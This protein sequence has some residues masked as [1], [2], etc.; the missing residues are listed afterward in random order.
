MAVIAIGV[1]AFLLIRF[2]QQTSQLAA[3][4][5]AFDQHAREASDALTEA[6]VA[7]HGYVAA[8]QGEDFWMSKVSASTEAFT[9]ALSVLQQSATAA[10]RTSI[11][12]A[13]ASATEFS[14]VDKRVRE[15]LK[16]DQQLMAAD[17]IFTEGSDAAATAGRQIETARLAGRQA[18]DRQAANIRRQEATTIGA[19]AAITGLIV[20]LL[21]PVR[22]SA[23]EPGAMVE[24]SS[25]MSI[26]PAMV[27]APAPAPV[28]KPVPP[29]APVPAPVPA[30]SRST[31]T[32]LFRKTADLATDFGRV[33]D[34]DEL[35]R[36]LA[37]AADLVDASGLM[38]WMAD[39]PGTIRPVMAHGYSTQM[40]A[41]MP[42]IARSADNAAAKA[43]RSGTLQIVLSRP[44]GISGAVVAPIMSP[45]G[46]IGALSAEIR[47]GAE[48][49][50]SVQ[51]LA[52]IFAAHLASVLATTSTG[53]EIAETRVATS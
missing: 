7:Q 20:M 4:L 45:D 39:T 19:A 35:T 33:R 51:A 1:S 24:A 17:V 15:Y 53:S 2:E 9:A 48:T 40:I 52:A 34:L 28:P 31:E 46:C 37:R 30:P 29:P 13:A 41:R 47:G 38:V 18:F 27:V 11:D 3:S 43:V 26:A 6:R 10:G 14:S 36:I 23:M 25:A 32:G 16:S 42:P 5:R 22:R 44:G 12:E 50:E 8:G 21:I 49:S